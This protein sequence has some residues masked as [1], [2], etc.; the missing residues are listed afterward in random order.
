MTFQPK[1][2]VTINNIEIEVPREPELGYGA[3]IHE[4]EDYLRAQELYQK[5]C[6]DATNNVPR[7]D[8][9]YEM[10]MS[11]LYQRAQQEHDAAE[12]ERV[13]RFHDEQ[14]RIFMSSEPRFI[15]TPEN[16]RIL[17]AEVQRRKLAGSAFDISEAFDYLVSTNQI[18]FKQI[19]T[20]VNLHPDLTTISLEE[21]Q[22]TIEA[23][24]KAAVT[25][26]PFDG[27]R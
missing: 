11:V 21:L 20:P 7:L 19:I 26:T 10:D 9:L 14:A 2:F 16:G 5:R 8:D 22:A 27:R 15:S 4:I 1:Q 25:P 17:A 13:A 24:Q 18:P 3:P 6:A 23:R 12:A